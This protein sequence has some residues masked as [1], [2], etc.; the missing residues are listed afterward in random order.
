MMATQ[1]APGG[2]PGRF[3]AQGGAAGPNFRSDGVNP[4]RKPGVDPGRSDGV[5][6]SSALPGG[7]T[8]E[9]GSRSGLRWYCGQVRPD[10]HHEARD[11]LI[12]QGFEAILPL[13]ARQMP[14]GSVRIY[15][16]FGPYL[17]VR[18]DVTRPG[19]RSICS[20]RGMK[21]LFGPTPE[22]PTPLRDRD[23]SAIRDLVISGEHG[24]PAVRGE[25]VRVTEGPWRGRTGLC[26]DVAAGVVRA[27]LFTTEGPRDCE[28]LA[29]WC[30]RA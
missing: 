29:R 16:L 10:M 24:G 9:C 30:K 20:T 15:P 13:G 11:R 2:A 6:R 22:Q 21:R 14:G 23:V 17:L 7:N 12:A 5:G 8:R 3:R 18:F 19:W 27:L 1:G 28:V 26:I 25:A 4:P